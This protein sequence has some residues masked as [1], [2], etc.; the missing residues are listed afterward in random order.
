MGIFSPTVVALL[1]K[2]SLSFFYCFSVWYLT[3]L[4]CEGLLLVVLVMVI[5]NECKFIAD[6]S[7]LSIFY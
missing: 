3:S 2:C 7:V 6:K 4:A 1:T 5:I